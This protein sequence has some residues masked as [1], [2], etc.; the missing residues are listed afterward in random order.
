MVTCHTA[1]ARDPVDAIYRY[2]IDYRQ[3]D[4]LGFDAMIIECVGA[5][6]VF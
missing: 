1:W 4:Q 3:L 2:G 5:L 6:D